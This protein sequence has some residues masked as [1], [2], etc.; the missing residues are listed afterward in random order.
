MVDFLAKAMEWVLDKEADAAKGCHAK[1]ED[2]DKQIEIMNKKK[3]A[4]E[5]Q[6]HDNLA[7]LE[8]IIDKLHFIRAQSL[9]CETGK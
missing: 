2:I 3:K 9:K 8:H 1:T 4:L 6:C 7:E 5:K